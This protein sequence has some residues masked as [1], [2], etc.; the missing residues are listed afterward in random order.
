MSHSESSESLVAAEIEQQEQTSKPNQQRRWP[1]VLGILLLLAGSG[2]GWIWWQ[3][4]FASNAP[5]G[6]TVAAGQP[7]GIPV[8]LATVETGTIQE[9]SVFPGELEAP[10]SVSLRPEIDGRISQ[11]LFRQGD[12]VQQGQV[13]IRLESDDAQ[14]RFRQAKASLERTQA[15]LAELKAGTRPEEIAQAKARLAQAE[16]RLQNAQAGASQK[17]LLRLKL[18]LSL[19]NPMWNWHSHERSATNN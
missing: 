9:A 6:D 18:K 2:F 4:R 12:R 15:R 19:L 16:T 14:A 8:K 13:I 3:N 11:I 17:K 7:M 1:L 5:A 10:R